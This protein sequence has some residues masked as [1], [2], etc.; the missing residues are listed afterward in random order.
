MKPV[1]L[2]VYVSYVPED[3]NWAVQ[4]YD[5]LRPMRDEVNLWFKGSPGRPEPPLQA[6]SLPLPWQILLFWYSPPDPQQIFEETKDP[7]RRENAHIYLFLTSYKS[8]NNNAI[9]DD[10]AL[11]ASRRIE[12]DWLSP[13]IKPVILAS[14]LWKE[15]SRLSGYKPIGP[16]K[17]LAEI[18]PVEEGLYEIATQ[19]SKTI[20]QMQRDLDEAKFL[21]VRTAAADTP[22]SRPPRKAEPY[23]GDE[24]DDSIF[25]YHPPAQ[26][27]LPEWLGWSLIFVLMLLGARG[28]Q[29]N[30]PHIS[31]GRYENAMPANAWQPELRREY[32]LMPPKEERPFPPPE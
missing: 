10:I 12:G 15:K 31:I 25:D 16:K 26:V 14:S 11:A 6:P 28:F 22:T 5:F 20:K 19:L 9:N 29:N 23:L 21:T 2:N 32:P 4:L 30:M 7:L 27:N 18:K 13:D 24:G 8:L 17:T 1:K 3:R